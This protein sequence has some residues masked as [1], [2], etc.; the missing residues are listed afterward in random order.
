MAISLTKEQ[1]R[2]PCPHCGKSLR[3]ERDKAGRSAKCRGCG[4]SVTVPGEKADHP[5]STANLE[6]LPASRPPLEETD[7]EL[8]PLELPESNSSWGTDAS[9]G[10]ASLYLGGVSLVLFLAIMSGAGLFIGFPNLGPIVLAAMAAGGLAVSWRGWHLA[11]EA[12]RHAR[13]TGQ[14]AGYA[15]AGRW[16][17][18]L[19][20]GNYLCLLL[21]AAVFQFMS[22][23]LL[24][25]NGKSG[26]GNLDLGGLLK[27]LQN[28]HNEANKLI[29]EINRR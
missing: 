3:A 6:A 5:E 23:G 11:G 17:H 4:Q 16:T 13:R 15:A 9:A 29:D 18:G 19:I 27:G 2:F 21:L 26:V 25:G 12:Q 28:Q 20:A 24:G 7:V 10:P 22:G 8:D 1:L 14:G